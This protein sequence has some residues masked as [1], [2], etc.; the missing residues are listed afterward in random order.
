M[1][2]ITNGVFLNIMV[3][4]LRLKEDQFMELSEKAI[5]ELLKDP[6]YAHLTEEKRNKKRQQLLDHYR[7]EY[8]NII[9]LMENPI[10]Q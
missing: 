4:S 5:T 6:R 9:A 1:L 2:G 10:Q 8:R 3:T 7:A